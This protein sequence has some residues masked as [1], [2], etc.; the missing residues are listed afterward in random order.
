MLED[1]LKLLFVVGHADTT[2]ALIGLAE[3]CN[4][5]QQSYM[6]FFT[7]EGVHQLADPSQ[8]LQDVLNKASPAVACQASWISRYKNTILPVDEGSQAD[9]SLL[10]AEAHK[11]VSL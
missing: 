9:H 10:L 1:E 5:A 2:S 6:C 4:R 3:A 8:A 7:G 11:V